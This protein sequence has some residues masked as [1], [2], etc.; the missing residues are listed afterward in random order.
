MTTHADYR[1]AAA[2]L[3]GPAGDFAAAEF[4]RLNRE[5]F[6]G[7]VPPLP[8]VIGLSAYGHC[9]GATR[10]DW[11]PVPRISLTPEIFTG[12]E[13]TPGGTLTV[14]DVLVHEMVHAVLMLR[15]EDR[16]HNS[17]PW[18]RMIAELSPGVLGHEISVRPVRPRRIPNPVRASDP[19]A[20]KTV[21]ARRALDGELTQDQLARWPM[22]LRPAAYY[23]AGRRLEVPTY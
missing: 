13:R 15:G 4:A 3:W 11:H 8:I 17:A 22:T 5:H 9:L 7:S 23:T 2:L 12:S 16:A 6:A 10:P 21:V 1:A 20:P 14:P 18:C 19:T